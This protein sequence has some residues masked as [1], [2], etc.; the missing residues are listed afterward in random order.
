MADEAEALLIYDEVQ[1]GVGLTGEFWAAQ[2]IGVMPDVIAFGKKTQVCGIL[3]G[4]RVDEVDDNVFQKSSRINSTWGGNLVDMVRF[5][6]ILEVIEDEDL[7]GNVRTQGDYLQSRLAA[8]AE[9]F[10]GVTDPRGRGL[11]CAFDLPDGATRNAVIKA[12]FDDGLI[13]LGCGPRTVRFRPALTIRQSDL[14][15][16]LDILERALDSTLR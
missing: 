11:L 5:D 6:R 2:S 8:L 1:T 9:R 4:R 7:V 13:A 14:D 10:D 12:A 15:V 16:G 3:A